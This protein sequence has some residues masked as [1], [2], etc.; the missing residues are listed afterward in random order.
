MDSYSCQNR[1]VEL[2]ANSKSYLVITL[3]N[4]PGVM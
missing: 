4:R 1:T 2:S 3:I